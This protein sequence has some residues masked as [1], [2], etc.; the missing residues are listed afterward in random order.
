MLKPAQRYEFDKK[1]IL[2][3]HLRKNMW[4]YFPSVMQDINFYAIKT[5]NNLSCQNVD[6]VFCLRARW[7]LGM[8]KYF[9]NMTNIILTEPDFWKK[10]HDG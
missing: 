1:K 7:L 10:L 4:K 3:K 6:N 2:Y 8:F 5:G 9:L